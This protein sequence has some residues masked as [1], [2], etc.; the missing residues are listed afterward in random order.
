[1]GRPLTG[2]PR[3][4]LAPA[5]TAPG[6]EGQRGEGALPARPPV[7]RPLPPLCQDHRRIS[8]SL[9]LH[10][11]QNWLLGQG[12]EPGEGKRPEALRL[13]GGR[14]RRAASRSPAPRFIGAPG[15][16]KEPLPSPEASSFRSGFGRGAASFTPPP[17]P[18]PFPS[19]RPGTPTP[20]RARACPHRGGVRTC[21]ELL[22]LPLCSPIAPPHLISKVNV[23]RV[24]AGMVG[25]A[26]SRNQLRGVSTEGPG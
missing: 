13:T 23:G 4:G 2:A 16:R 5:L 12:R 8:Q 7:S 18:R 9:F 1:M 21:L 26:D 20:N 22:T 14:R 15:G 3:K 6:G 17:P 24:A 25:A 19:S 11:G 10:L